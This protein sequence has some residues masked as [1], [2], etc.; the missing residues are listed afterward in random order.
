MAVAGLFKVSVLKQLWRSDRPEFL[1]AVAATVGML[2]QGLLRGVMI[3]A[4]ASPKPVA[5]P[6]V[7]LTLKVLACRSSTTCGIGETMRSPPR[8]PSPL[9]IL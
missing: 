8:K 5:V 6:E 2:G 1:V 4:G 7:V 9:P 3:G